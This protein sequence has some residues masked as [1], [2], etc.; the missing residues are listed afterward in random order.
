MF[1]IAPARSN[2]SF[3]RSRAELSARLR[4]RRPE[5]EQAV[6]TRA[7]SV[8]NAGE[9]V[10]PD[11]LDPTYLEGLRTAIS[12]AVDYG[13]EIIERGEERAPSPPPVLLA[14][15]RLAARYGIGLDTVLRRYSAGYVLLTDYLVEEAENQGLR[16]VELQR[17]LR[18]R[19]ALD[20]LLAVVSEEYSREVQERPGTTE[21]RRAERVERLL[22]GELLDTSELAY[23]FE[24]THLAVIA[25]GEGTQEALKDLATAFGSRLLTV[26]RSEE[27]LWA[28]LGSR[29]PLE[30]CALHR[31]ASESW[32]EGVKVA[33]GEQGLG[34]AGWRLS[35]R[36]AKAAL[37]VAMRSPEPFVRY[38]DVAL[39]AVVLQDELLAT[40][41]RR[42]YLEPLQA[43]RDG[44]EV[45]IETLRAYFAAGRN[46]S[47]AA[48][49][50]GVSRQ[51]VGSRLRVVEDRLGR[52]LDTC[53]AELEVALRLTRL[54]PRGF[55]A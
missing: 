25:W 44:G 34:L 9:P 11:T 12:A 42:L 10:D 7:F 2:S 47:S 24:C 20:H 40:T 36:Q 13:M 43:E 16:G 31:Y 55:G 23:E 29:E 22:A 49:G 3:E 46:V 19:A 45:A 6:L 53:A 48:V 14:Q 4:S 30:M 21:E 15:A 41:L 51:A 33:I 18:A 37:P 39:L 38:V 54:G 52:Q 50:L 1:A 27:A 8:T 17:L 35:H 28:W 32:P 5:I 26:P